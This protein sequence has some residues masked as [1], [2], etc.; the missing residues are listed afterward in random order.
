MSY[1]ASDLLHVNGCTR[2]VD[3]E[4][5]DQVWLLSLAANRPG[6]AR[7]GRLNLALIRSVHH[8]EVQFHVGCHFQ[9]PSL[10]YKLHMH[11]M[12]VVLLIVLATGEF[13]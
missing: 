6:P 10:L 11:W 9:L 2:R 12:Y 1:Y 7:C 3:A 5:W 8:L 13:H 4:G